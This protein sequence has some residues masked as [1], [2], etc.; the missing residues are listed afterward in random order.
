MTH[1]CLPPSAPQMKHRA[2][3][4]GSIRHAPPPTPVPSPKDYHKSG[5]TFLDR[6]LLS[7]SPLAEQFEP[8]PMD[9][10]P[11]HQRMNGVS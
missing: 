11:Q 7:V 10:I 4:Q 2:L 3:P 5:S 1:K 8:T 6:N 9:P